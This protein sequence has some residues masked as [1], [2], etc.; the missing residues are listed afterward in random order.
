MPVSQEEVRHWMDRL[1]FNASKSEARSFDSFWNGMLRTS[2]ERSKTQS[3]SHVQFLIDSEIE[4]TIR[5]D[6]SPEDSDRILMRFDDAVLNWNHR[7]ESN[8]VFHRQILDAG[9]LIVI[10]NGSEIEVTVVD[11]SKRAKAFFRFVF[12]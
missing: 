9:N 5:C 2:K 1:I 4:G 6:S 12:L 11:D 8:I 7:T 3:R 10:I